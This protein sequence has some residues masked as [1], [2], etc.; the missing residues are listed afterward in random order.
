MR[1]VGRLAV[2]LR[3]KEMVRLESD[4]ALLRRVLPDDIIQRMQARNLAPSDA[5]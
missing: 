5:I 2:Q 3:L 1:Q 4:A